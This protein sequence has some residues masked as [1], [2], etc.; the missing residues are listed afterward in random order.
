M[1]ESLKE[2]TI[3]ALIWNFA[4]RFGQQVLQFVVAV[5][6]ANILFPDDYALV[7]ML[8][9]FTA[10]GNLIIE[11]G[12]GAA[13]IQKKQADDRDFSTVFW[14]NLAMSLVLYALLIMATPLI[15]AYFHEPL[16]TRIAAVVFLGL[17]LNASM[18]IQN[19][20]LNKQIRFKRLAQV[21]LLSMLFSSACA[22][23]MAAGGCGVWT[24]AWQPVTLAASKSALERLAA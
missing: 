19:T 23:G 10:I 22:I 13:L 9:I 21:D 6:V 3:G 7:A 14:F 8:A 12:F 20:L 4:D 24:L 5:I 15:V 11:S 16:L 2:K 17:P 18:L 1:P